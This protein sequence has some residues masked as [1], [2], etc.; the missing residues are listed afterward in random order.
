MRPSDPSYNSQL[1]LTVIGDI[2][3]IWDE[4]TGDGVITAVYDDGVEYT[5][6]DLAANYDSSL[7]FTFGGT[8][9]SPDPNGS[10]DGHGTSVAGIIAGVSNNIGGVGVAF[11]ATL[12][13][14]EFLGDIFNIGLDREALEFGQN[15]DVINA[16]WGFTPLY[17]DFQNS[18]DP[19]SQVSLD[20]DALEVA[21]EDGRDGLGTSFIHSAGN[22]F[23]N[24]NGDGFNSHRFTTSIAATE[25]DGFIA[26]YSNHGTSILV[27]AP[28]DN[29][30]TDL[31][32]SDGYTN[33]NYFSSFNGTS[34]SAPVV[35]GIV[36]L[37]YEAEEGLGWRDVQN[38]LAI[39]ASHTGSDFSGGSTSFENG[40]WFGNSATN[41]N[42]GSMSFH[43]SYGFGQVDAFAAVRMAEAWLEIYDD[44]LTSANE[45][46]MSFDGGSGSI[47]DN[48][49]LTRTITVGANDNMMIEDITLTVDIFHTWSGDLTITLISPDGTE[50]I[51]VEGEGGSTDVDDSWNFG[52][53]GELAAFSEGTWTLEILDSALGDTGTLFDWDLTFYGSD[54][55]NDDVYHFTS[56]FLYYEGFEASRS[57]VEDSNGGE[58]WLNFAAI[59]GDIEANLINGRDIEV[60]GTLW[61]SLASDA[62]I[63][64]FYSGD[65]DDDIIGSSVANE[66]HGG[67][68]DDTIDGR[69]GHDEI[70]G[71]QGND[72]LIGGGGND[73][74]HG[75]DGEDSLDGGTGTDTASYEDSTRNTRVDLNNNARNVG[76]ASGDT[77]ISIEGVITGTGADSLFGVSSVGE[78]LDG[79]GGHDRIFGRGG[80]D[81]IVGGGGR[82]VIYSQGGSDTITGGGGADEFF[83]TRLADSRGSQIDTIT[84][85]AVGIDTIDLSRID[86]VVG[87][88]GNQAFDFVGNAGFSNTAGELIFFF[89]GQNTIVQ[90]DVKGNGAADFELIL[91]GDIALTAG[92]FVL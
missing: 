24:H 76:D 52:I 77:L 25:I 48:S 51:V 27:S 21:I 7:E 55:T 78:Y 85:F 83:F 6:P 64:N 28:A 91:E 30:T 36:A 18:S 2:E 19:F 22:D 37:M 65:G 10:D 41:W 69:S 68:G 33:G 62:D 47:T 86:A 58:D 40:T 16:S 59:A 70:H 12:V 32:G 42:G 4:F 87:G 71:G 56:D 49:T 84:D 29:F 74:L 75:G 5:H 54:V 46:S 1:H 90:A 73:T 45:V 60:D 79:G 92:D 53:T 20:L 23:I 89:D 39:S 50:Y 17:N 26:D 15:Y 9:Y 31:T 35:S 72:M 11:D 57:T 38:I 63:E 34:A 81:T 80:D 61:T 14:V 82:D 13:G 66:I 67:R 43:Q 8:R 3:T 88:G 44:A